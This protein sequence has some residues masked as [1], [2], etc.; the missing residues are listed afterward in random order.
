MSDPDSVSA[1]LAQGNDL[2]VS[3]DGADDTKFLDALFGLISI[4]AQVI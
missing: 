2:P 3:P 1:D 4:G